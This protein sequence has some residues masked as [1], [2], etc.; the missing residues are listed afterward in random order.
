MALPLKWT[1]ARRLAP[2]QAPQPALPKAPG[3]VPQPALPEARRVSQARR[4]QWPSDAEPDR[5]LPPVPLRGG[6]SARLRFLQ[7]GS[8]DVAPLRAPPASMAASPVPRTLAHSRTQRRA[9]PQA[10][11]EPPVRQREERGFA[12]RQATWAFPVWKRSSVGPESHL[13]SRLSAHVKSR[14]PCCRRRAGCP[15]PASVAARAAVHWHRSPR[16]AVASDATVPALACCRPTGTRRDLRPRRRRNPRP[17]M[18][19]WDRRLPSPG[20]P[21]DGGDRRDVRG[22]ANAIP[23]D[24]LRRWPS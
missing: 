5:S 24:R 9:W 23:R 17:P 14:A 12:R 3:H 8:Q 15:R 2:G 16:T 6:R 10:L 18:V 13:A 20:R 21:C 4:L 22:V 1:L 11:R 19:N 7:Q